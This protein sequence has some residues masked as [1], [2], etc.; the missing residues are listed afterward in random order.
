MPANYL[1]CVYD[2]THANCLLCVGCAVLHIPANYF[3]CVGCSVLYMP[4]NYFL[5]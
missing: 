5:C 4:A 3:L 2:T 1:L